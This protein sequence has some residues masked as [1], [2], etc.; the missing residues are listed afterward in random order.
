MPH[1][2]LLPLAV[3]VPPVAFVFRCVLQEQRWNN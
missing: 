1:V 3:V 2:T